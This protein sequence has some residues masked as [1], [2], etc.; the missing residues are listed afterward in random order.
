MQLHGNDAVE[1]ITTES[2]LR[3]V[4][5]LALR[6]P[7]VAVDLESDGFYHYPDRV[8][9]LQLATPDEI[10]LIDTLSTRDVTPI[11][12]L[13]AN[14]KVE[15]IFHSADYDIRSL[16]RD[17]GFS[18]RNLFDTSIATA[19]IGSERRG[20]AAVLLEYLNV[21][22][23]KDKK[24]QR[25]DWSRRPLSDELLKYAA[26]DVRHLHRLRECLYQKLRDLD[27]IKWV[28]EECQ[29]LA[30]VVYN[31]PDAERGFLL[32]KGA[33]SLDGQGLAV[34]RSIH[35]FREKEA[36][37]RNLP[38]FKILS[39]PVILAVAANPR[40]EIGQ[41][42]GIGRYGK[43]SPSLKLRQAI[44][45]GLEALPFK[46]PQTRLQCE[47][48]FKLEGHKHAKDRL[49]LLKG[50]RTDQANRLKLNEGLLWPAASLERLS[51]RTDWFER[52]LTNNSIREWQRGAL[53]ESLRNFT[54]SI[55]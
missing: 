3:A 52:E 15:K 1:V 49:R 6:Q 44:R 48:R 7:R 51:K 37:R 19:F 54:K 45:D 32:V 13:M 2:D 16:D 43:G 55:D 39:N 47:G 10:Y 17:W 4:V 26:D 42:K 14:D 9:L 22:V 8:C 36:F 23:N 30:S 27:R 24:L 11:G 29:R 50:W 25:A 20:L 53:G 18:V 12:D 40:S 21:R 34:L 41:F 31:P 46:P 5:D 28:Q 35:T 38:P 33:R